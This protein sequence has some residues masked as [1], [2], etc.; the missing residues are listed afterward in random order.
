MKKRF[1][2][3]ILILALLPLQ[4]V[5]AK[6]GS[7]IPVK[8]IQCIDGNTAE[9]S[10]I[11]V[12]RLLYVETP[13]PKSL[14]EPYGKEA[15]AFTCQSL[16][17]AKKIEAQF[18]GPMKDKANRSLAWIFVDGKLL[19]QLLLQ[20]GYVKKINDNGDYSYEE[21]LHDDFE[22]AKEKHIGL[23]KVKKPSGSDKNEKERD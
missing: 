11:G 19:Q 1:L 3:I 16:S 18:D 20:K 6:A 7:R 15:L 2:L 4:L 13:D 21:K 8:L 14:I 12:T 23:W 9:F 10:K 17:K 22:Y 5:D